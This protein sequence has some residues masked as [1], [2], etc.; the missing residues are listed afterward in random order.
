MTSRS[1][2]ESFDCGVGHLVPFQSC[3]DTPAIKADTEDAVSE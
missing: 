3:R 2:V 1:L